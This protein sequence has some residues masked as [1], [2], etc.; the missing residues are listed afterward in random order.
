MNHRSSRLI[1]LSS[2]TGA[3]LLIAA[4]LNGRGIAVGADDQLTNA[5]QTNVSQPNVSQLNVAATTPVSDD[6]NAEQPERGG[7]SGKRNPMPTFTPE[8]EAAA[9]TFVEAHHPELSPLLKQLKISRPNEYQKAIRKLFGDSERLA[10]NREFQPLR[11][12]LELNDWKL[13]SRIQLLIARLAIEPTDQR[14]K[15]LKKALEEQLSVRR[16]LMAFER[17]RL[18]QRL[19]VLDEELNE[20]DERRPKLVD[21][22]F[23]KA[24]KSAGQKKQNIKTNK[25]GDK[26]GKSAEKK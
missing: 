9:L 6:R 25:N 11:Y 10:H 5:S 18:A 7:K 2:A 12:D 17:A 19:A 22:L 16:E 8:R 23:D 26:D 3:T 20:F 21:E 13:D 15:E 4:L 1:V 24:L 14:E